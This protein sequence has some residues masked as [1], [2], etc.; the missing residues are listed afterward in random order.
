MGFLRMGAKTTR[1]MRS[2]LLLLLAVVGVRGHVADHRYNKGDHVE[3]WVNKVSSYRRFALS[4]S[5]QGQPA[6]LHLRTL[7]RMRAGRMWLR[8]RGVRT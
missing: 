1:M 2:V 7:G 8:E 3:L 6:A 4:K 5:C